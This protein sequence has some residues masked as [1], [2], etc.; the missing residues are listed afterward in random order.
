MSGVH[1]CPAC[2][3]NTIPHCSLA[4]PKK[5]YPCEWWRCPRGACMSF[6]HNVKETLWVDMRPKDKR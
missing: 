1:V 4:K 6:G 2:G 3:T 5:Q